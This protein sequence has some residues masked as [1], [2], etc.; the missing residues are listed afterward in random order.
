MLLRNLWWRA[1]AVSIFSCWIRIELRVVLFIPLLAHGSFF[2]KDL[3]VLKYFIIQGVRGL[4]I[5][6]LLFFRFTQ[7]F[8][9]RS[10]MGVIFVFILKTGTFPFFQW[11][12]SLGERVSWYPL[13]I[14]LSLQK[15]IPLIFIT[16][17]C[18][19]VV[20]LISII[21][22][23]VLPILVVNRKKIKPVVIMS[24]V[25]L[26]LAILCSLCGSTFKWKSLMLLYLLTLGPLASMGDRSDN[27][28]RSLGGC[29]SPAFLVSWRVLLLRLIGLPPLPGF[30]IKVELF[31]LVIERRFVL[32]IAFL[33]GS[34]VM[35]WVYVNLWFL[36]II[37]RANLRVERL[38]RGTAAVVAAATLLGAVLLV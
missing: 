29:A 10:A 18:S 19:R 35:T 9:R 33:A 6:S 27:L 2:L 20:E 3:V 36:L 5:L 14:L 8:S 22:W 32:T 37:A 30:L 12:V 1:G 25:F 13:F 15:I 24:S 31:R 23:A 17:F 16:Y 7:D 28:K 21:G 4:L 11:V 34:I 26:F 38:S